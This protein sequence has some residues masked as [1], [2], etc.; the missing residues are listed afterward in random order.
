[1]ENVSER[2]IELDDLTDG[3][4]G[5]TTDGE[6]DPV[7]LTFLLRRYRATGRDDLTDTL[8]SAL[9]RAVDA[10]RAATSCDARSR[11]LEAFVMA[12]SLS[13][14]ARM[15]WA[16]ADLVAGLQAEWRRTTSVADLVTSVDACLQATTVFESADLVRGA[17]DEL[18]RVVAS[19]YRPG[20]GIAATIGAADGSSRRLAD[21]IR[22]AS[23]LVTACVGTARLPYGMLAEEL[24]QF[25]R[26][27][28]WDERA[29][30]F[31]GGQATAAEFDANCDAVRV[32]CRLSRLLEDADYQ[33]AAVV[34]PDANYRDDASRI[35][36]SQL[37]AARSNAGAAAL[38]ALA[39][40]EW[41]SLR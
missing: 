4:L 15:R 41:L 36:A 7:A 19:A 8:G 20:H 1:V 28:F 31:V 26:R 29:G 24:V 12:A 25:A 40:D 3:V 5:A 9:A 34:A 13:S 37:A 11:W 32:L 14:D 39:L 33:R 27:T 38:Y 22:S 30:A 23:A 16:I 17:I 2:F 21:Q 18:E 6:C 35:L 10:C